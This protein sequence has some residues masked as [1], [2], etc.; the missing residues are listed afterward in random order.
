VTNTDSGKILT[1]ELGNFN[2]IDTK[3]FSITIAYVPKDVAQVGL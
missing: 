2:L 3:V 1:K